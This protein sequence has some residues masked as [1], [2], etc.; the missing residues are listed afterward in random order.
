MN[1]SA[2]HA[3]TVA[4]PDPPLP[5]SRSKKVVGKPPAL[6][7]SPLPASLIEMDRVN[8]LPVC[9]FK[10]PSDPFAPFIFPLPEYEE[11]A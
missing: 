3:E 2:L 7:A 9:R 10:R 1:R 6:I 5:S 8:V 4:L 11:I